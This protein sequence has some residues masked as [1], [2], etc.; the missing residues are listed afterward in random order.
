MAYAA[1]ASGILCLELLRPSF[2][3]THPRDRSISRS[4]IIQSLSLLVGCLD[5]I[6]S[7]APNGMLCANCKRIVQ[8]VLD[9]RLNATTETGFNLDSFDWDVPT[10]VEFDFA[11]LD[12]FDWLHE[13]MNLK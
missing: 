7:T 5:Q 1:P 11:L 3:N 6:H 12:T 8:Y 2:Q 10:Q 9:Y 13:D 4:T